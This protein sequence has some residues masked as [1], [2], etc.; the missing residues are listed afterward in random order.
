MDQM[1]A[2]AISAD[3]KLAELIAGAAL[4]TALLCG[5]GSRGVGDAIV[6]FVSVPVLFLACRRCVWAAASLQQRSAMALLAAALAWHVLQLIP[7]P[8]GWIHVLPMR[9]EMLTDLRTAGMEPCCLRATMDLWGTVRSLVALMTFGGYF[10]L[11]CTLAN[12]SRLRLLK[13]LV[14]AGCAMALLGYA[15]AAA[16]QNSQLR[17]YGHHHA[18]G[19]LGTF[20]N[21]NHFASLMAMLVPVALSLAACGSR[22]RRQEN[23]LWSAAA[24]VLLLGACLTFSRTGF[25]LACASGITGLVMISLRRE[26]AFVGVALLMLATVGM[27]SIYAWGE[28]SR[29][30]QQDP[31]TDLRWQYL[32]Y[33]WK[34]AT[35]YFPLGSGPG[36]FRS[37][38]AAIE[39]IEKM[40]GTYALHAHNDFLEI[41]IESGL[42]GVMLVLAAIG[43]LARAVRNK[44]IV[45]DGLSPIPFGSMIAV[46]VPV[47]HSL[48]DYPLRTYAVSATCALV[49]SIVLSRACRVTHRRG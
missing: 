39:P 37:V 33:G 2:A 40:G 7:L 8:A 26:R 35:S 11:F 22:G 34:A 19:A 42:P 10:V 6:S 31:L 5:G 45:G 41:A 29:R 27:V 20:A 30:L 23:A 21:R 14:V 1:R 32:R 43:L 48:V 18:T 13:L 28:L 15:Q 44:L 36:S 4:I 46:T 47:L 17:L 3:D 16:G 25:I 9:A 38:Y 12:D 49:S 24:L